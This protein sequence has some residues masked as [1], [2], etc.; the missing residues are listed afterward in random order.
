MDHLVP[1]TKK[2]N[3]FRFVY[4]C[5]RKRLSLCELRVAVRQTLKHKIPFSPSL[6]LFIPTS[7]Q[8]ATGSS[9]KTLLP[10][11]YFYKSWLSNRA[12]TLQLNLNVRPRTRSAEI[13]KVSRVGKCRALILPVLWFIFVDRT[14]TKRRLVWFVTAVVDFVAVTI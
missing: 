1:H 7:E 12:P 4:A 10:K 13:P 2:K 11:M 14:C 6:S 3:H 8:Y 9:E 5:L